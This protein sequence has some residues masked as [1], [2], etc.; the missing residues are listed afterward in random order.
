M[1]I[2][3]LLGALVGWWLDGR[4]GLKPWLLIVGALLGAGAGLFSFVR[5]ML[6]LSKRDG[7]DRPD[8]DGKEQLTRR[9]DQ[10][11]DESPR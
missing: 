2:A 3:T 7:Q 11:D 8:T 1:V 4:F 6:A 9:R 10:N 5:S